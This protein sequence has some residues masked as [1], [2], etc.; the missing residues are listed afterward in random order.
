MYDRLRRY[1]TLF[2]VLLDI[3]LMNLSFYIAYYGRYELQWLRP[4]APENFVPISEYIPVFAAL[5]V[6]LLL[7][8]RVEGLYSLP[9]SAS[10]LD[11][12]Y[13]IAIGTLGGVAIWIVLAFIYRPLFYS[14]LFLVFA[15]LITTAMLSISRLLARAVQWR[16]RARG[17]GLERVLIVGAGEKSRALVQSL[18]AQPQLGYQVVG[19]LDDNPQ[20]LQSPLGRF[21]PLGRT[22]NLDRVLKEQ[23]IDQVII[24]L[25]AISQQRILSLIDQCQEAGVRVRILPDLFQMSLARVNVEEIGGLPLLGIK[26][27]SI[28]G[29]N[30]TLKRTID[31]LI[32]LVGFILLLPLTALLVLAIKLES[33]GPVLFRQKR[34]GRDGQP[35]TLYKFRSMKPGAEEELPSLTDL[36]QAQGIFFKMRDDPRIT[37]VGRL[38]RRTSLDEF[39][40]LLNVLRGEMSLVGPRP[41]LPQEVENYQE[42]HKKRWEVQPGLTGLWQVMGRSDLS[43]DEMVMLDLY[44]IENWSLWLD[45]K[46]LLLTIPTVLTGRGAY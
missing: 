32:S 9:R 2:W 24:T 36:N 35:F 41:G 40:Q 16:L 12:I 14:R 34:I 27:V 46:I 38:L 30:Q 8:Y 28:R 13:T 43:F 1:R 22:S 18:L 21:P 6:F 19:F 44:Y 25:P 20:N 10:W 15:T 23:D 29:W 11:E 26:E 4:V 5:T 39:P 3:L 7:V 42:W 17:I 37:R 33:R 45:L 31:L